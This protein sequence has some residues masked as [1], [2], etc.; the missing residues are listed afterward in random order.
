MFLYLF[1]N[2]LEVN[3]CV[4]LNNR[5]VKDILILNNFNILFKVLLK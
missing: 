5:N 3:D 4:Y 2:I 1:M